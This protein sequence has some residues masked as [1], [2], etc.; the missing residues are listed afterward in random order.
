MA[1][2]EVEIEVA[3]PAGA[4]FDVLA[5][6][7]AFLDWN[8]YEGAE[9]EVAGEGPGMVRTLIL[10]GFGRIGERLDTLDRGTHTL[11][12]SLVEGTPIGM[13]E[14]RAQVRVEAAGDDRCRLLW[15]GE[16]EPAV[17]M[18]EEDV[19]PLLRQSYEL[20]SARLGEYLNRR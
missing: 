17:G 6:F 13:A 12:Y 11:R 5:D 2:L 1:R 15:H 14:Y 19:A 18:A 20:M 16:F 4:A 10:P 9:L 8:A 3:A 7:G